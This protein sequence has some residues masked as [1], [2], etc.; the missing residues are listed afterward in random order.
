M[1]TSSEVH[2]SQNVVSP[3]IIFDK[4]QSDCEN[5]DTTNVDSIHVEDQ[6]NQPVITAKPT[7][8][9]D[10]QFTI[11]SLSAAH[12]LSDT[13]HTNVTSDVVSNT[14]R[15][16]VLE[17]ADLHESEINPPQALFRLEAGSGEISCDYDVSDLHV[18]DASL[19]MDSLFAGTKRPANSDPAD[20]TGTVRLFYT[21]STFHCTTQRD[22]ELCYSFP[23]HCSA[24]TSI[25]L[26]KRGKTK[27]YDIYRPARTYSVWVYRAIPILFENLFILNRSYWSHK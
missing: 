16:G 13:E 4:Q 24:S 22:A 25:L 23:Y 6:T 21:I 12:T 10:I 9:N 27:M 2:I 1:T 18:A 26:T 3:N 20:E 7:D 14:D 17:V 8:D 5:S 19:V 15:H 11:T